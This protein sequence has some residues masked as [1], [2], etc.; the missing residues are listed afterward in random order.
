MLFCYSI[1]QNPFLD[2]F[3]YLGSKGIQESAL[4]LNIQVM[5]YL[6]TFENIAE[7]IDHLELSKERRDWRSTQKQIPIWWIKYAKILWEETPV[8]ENV[9]GGRKAGQN[10]RLQILSMWRRQEERLDRGLLECPVLQERL[11]LSWSS[12]DKGHHQ[13]SSFVA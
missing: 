2:K 7:N 5:Y 11:R 12:W 3:D 1:T 8:K 10:F 4:L 9:E 13:R 6:F